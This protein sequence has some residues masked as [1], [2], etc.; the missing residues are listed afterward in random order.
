LKG[1]R[2]DGQD[3]E[4]AWDGEQEERRRMEEKI[5]WNEERVGEERGRD[6]ERERRAE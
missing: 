4:D 2:A 5:G 1:E 3:E 6:E